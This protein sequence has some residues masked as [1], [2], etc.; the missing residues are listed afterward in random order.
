[1][2]HRN[3]IKVSHRF[4]IYIFIFFL[5]IEM[6]VIGLYGLYCR[7]VSSDSI[8]FNAFKARNL[9]IKTIY[10]VK[11]CLCLKPETP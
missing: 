6:C 3:K 9:S 1:M 5:V 10:I 7:I 8:F 2:Y 4:F 11:S